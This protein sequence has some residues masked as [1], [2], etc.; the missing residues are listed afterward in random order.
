MDKKKKSTKDLEL[1]K[2]KKHRE[3]RNT[4]KSKRNSR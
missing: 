4:S 3:A 2:Q 1:E